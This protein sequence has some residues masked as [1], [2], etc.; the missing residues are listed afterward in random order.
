MTD[1]PEAPEGF[2][3]MVEEPRFASAPPPDWIRPIEDEPLVKTTVEFKTTGDVRR[4]DRAAYE[5][6]IEAARASGADINEVGDGTSLPSGFPMK[7]KTEFSFKTKTVGRDGNVKMHEADPEAAK[8]A[9][10]T[11]AI[12]FS[13]VVAFGCLAVAVAAWFLLDVLR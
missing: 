9:V 8:A 11:G 1:E 3:P 10:K 12:V 5:A 13:L 7:V 2:R 4:V 6:A